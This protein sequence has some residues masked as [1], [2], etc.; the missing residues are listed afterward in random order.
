MFN[1]LWSIDVE[2]QYWISFFKC[3]IVIIFFE[4]YMIIAPIMPPVPILLSLPLNVM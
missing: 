3:F 2:Y 4:R 1:G